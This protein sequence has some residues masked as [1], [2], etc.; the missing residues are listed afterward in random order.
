MNSLIQWMDRNLY[1]GVEPRW[2]D[3]AFR[4]R[5]LSSILP[6]HK[7]LDL[8]AGAGIV[9]EMNFKGHADKICGIDL[10]P[11]VKNNTL[12]DEGRIADAECIPYPDSSFDLVFADNVMEHLERPV[13][14]FKEI[15][16]VLRPGGKLLFKTPNACH[17]M[18]VIARLTP[19]SFHRFINRLRGR[20]SVDTFPTRYRSNTRSDIKR[21]ADASGFEIEAIEPIEGRPEYMRIAPPLYLLGF[22]Y[23]RLVNSTS[24]LSGFRVLLIATLRKPD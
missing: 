17:Y 8:G 14:V 12:L 20:K 13:V 16:R 11:R 6:H 15:H 5:I 3:L 22:F 9:P 10:D 24:L 21:I 18:P 7:V 4:E 19:H 23:E 2:D 1:L